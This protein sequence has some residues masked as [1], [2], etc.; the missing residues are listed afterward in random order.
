MAFFDAGVTDGH[1]DGYVL[2][3][4][5]YLV[6]EAFGHPARPRKIRERLGQFMHGPPHDVQLIS[7]FL[8]VQVQE[9]I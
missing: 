5:V 8:C 3:E 1:H 6:F 7:D 2:L 9:R 4:L